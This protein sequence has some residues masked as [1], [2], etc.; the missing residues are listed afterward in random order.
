M[1]RDAGHEAYFAGGCVRDLVMGVPPHDYDVT[2]SARPEEVMMLFRK[3]VPVGAAFGVVL[4][5]LGGHEYEVATFRTEGA[6]SDGRHPDSVAYAT[7]EEDVTRRDFTI[8]GLLYDPVADKV[9]DH[10]GGRDDI[11]RGIVR[12]IGDADERFAED[13]LRLW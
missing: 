3:T 12:T 4:V 6:Y 13:Q 9:I 5:I 1:L 10:V 11:E 2:T 7:A 8:N